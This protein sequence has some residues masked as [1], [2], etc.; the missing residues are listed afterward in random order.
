MARMMSPRAILRGQRA[1]VATSIRTPLSLNS[2]LR[3]RQ[4]GNRQPPLVRNARGFG[5]GIA[6]TGL[7][8]GLS[9]SISAMTID[10]SSV[11]PRRKTVTVLL[12]PGFVFTHQTRQ[13]VCNP[14]DGLAVKA[15][16]DVTGLHPAFS[17]G[18]PL[19]TLVTKA[20]CCLPSPRDSATSRVT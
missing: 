16:N 11:L 14:L 19:S 10:R 17:A 3:S 18:E 1:S 9:P 6:L 4:V 20:P 13:R 15:H 7:D 12:V 2:F 5:F 8:G